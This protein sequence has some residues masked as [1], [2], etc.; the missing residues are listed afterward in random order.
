VDAEYSYVNPGCS[1]VAL[2]MMA[3]FNQNRPVVANTYQCYFKVSALFSVTEFYEYC[4]VCSVWVLFWRW[5]SYSYYLILCIKLKYEKNVRYHHH[6]LGLGEELKM[7]ERIFMQFRFV[8]VY[9]YTGLKKY[10]RHYLRNQTF[11]HHLN[12]LFEHAREEEQTDVIY[13]NKTQIK[14]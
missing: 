14:Y 6:H 8:C 4:S 7:Q 3:V 12:Y 10:G 2:A 13:E 11:I 1:L 5:Y 9:L